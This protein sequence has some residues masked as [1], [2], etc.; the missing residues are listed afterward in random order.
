MPWELLDEHRWD[1]RQQ[2]A[3][4]ISEWIEAWYDPLGRRSYC[5]MLSLMTVAAMRRHRLTTNTTDRSD[6]WLS[7]LPRSIGC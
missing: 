4:A 7:P 6:S 1:A 2:L 5:A 3:L